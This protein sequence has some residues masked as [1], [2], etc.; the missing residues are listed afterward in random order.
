MFSTYYKTF[1]KTWPNN[2][3]FIL[4]SILL[5]IPA[6][7]LGEWSIYLLTIIFLITLCY[8][9][10]ERF[11]IA[12]T[13]ITL[14]TLV[15]ELNKSLRVVVHLVDFTLLG[16][17]FLKKYG[18]NFKDY[19]RIPNSILYF[20]LFFFAIMIF[21]S[22]VSSYPFAGIGIITEQIEFFIIVYVFY[23]LIDNESDIKIYISAVIV[24]AIIFVII[25]LIAFFFQ[26]NSLIDI[27]TKNRTRIS[28]VITNPEVFPN[29]YIFT[30]PIALTVLL[31]RKQFIY[32]AI[33]SIIL[34]CICIGLILTM[35]R[36]AILG[37]I[38]NSSI[39][40]FV[41]KRKWFYRFLL[42]LIVLGLIILL[43]EPLNQVV[44]LFFRIEEGTSARSQ[45]WSMSFNI[46]KDHPIFGLGPGAYKYEF[47]NY[48]PFMLSNWWGRL[49][50]YYY[51]VT[52]GINFSHN[53]FLVLFTEMGI[54]GFIA[55]LIL[56]I[57]YFTIGLKTVKKYSIEKSDSYYL[58][59]CL[60]AI[61]TTVIV[62]NFFNSIG[63][64]YLGGLTANLP[65][66]LAFSSLIYFYYS[67]PT[68][69]SLN[70]NHKKNQSW[71]GL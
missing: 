26:G 48:I 70:S 17:I 29:F 22:A 63:L 58:I 25:S 39:I 66:W 45:I 65:F 62:R 24:A 55:A 67:L 50:I 44:T 8:I 61:G 10:G 49:L 3:N 54:L 53:Y 4:L 41:T 37:V 52:N 14:F 6:L 12:L 71:F 60:F 11:I 2:I 33:S 51:E 59:I 57:I 47:F 9:F 42:T 28:V 69:I 15:G 32:K 34:I 56:P 19:R 31:I 64:L 5:S 23:S 46:I 13:L 68:Q 35:S 40:L 16:F 21:S 20:L 27:I 1:Q 43:Y 36:S 38:I 18:L 30:F 7:L